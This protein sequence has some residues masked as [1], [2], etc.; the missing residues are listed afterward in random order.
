MTVQAKET[1][2]K[3]SSSTFYRFLVFHGNQDMNGKV[4]KKKTGSKK[5]SVYR[6]DSVL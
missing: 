4:E 3:S 2:T 5:Y 6:N 1:T